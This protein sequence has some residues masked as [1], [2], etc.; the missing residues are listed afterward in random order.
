[1]IH[2]T[3]KL[4]INSR[5]NLCFDKYAHKRVGITSYERLVTFIISN[6]RYIFELCGDEHFFYFTGLQLITFTSNYCPFYHQTKITIE[7]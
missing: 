4:K 1:M 6:R 3:K 5:Y 7:F 2:N